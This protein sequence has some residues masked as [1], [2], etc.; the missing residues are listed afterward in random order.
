MQTFNSSA[1]RNARLDTSTIDYAV[2]PELKEPRAAESA[3]R[4][5]LLP[6]NFMVQYGPEQPDGPLAAP[7]IV[8]IAAGP[9]HIAPAALTE[10][11]GFDIGGIELGFVHRE[12]RDERDAPAQGMLTDLWK[13]LMDDVF[14]PEQGNTKAA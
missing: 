4:M 13:G 1:I 8:V 3:I 12:A 2:F 9:H 11:E 7:E 5:P 14:G 10:V 6:D